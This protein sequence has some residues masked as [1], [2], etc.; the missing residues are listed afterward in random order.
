MAGPAAPSSRPM[1]SS[2]E[3]LQNI[4]KR[5]EI[6]QASLG[7]WR[8]LASGLAGRSTE[9]NEA[10]ASE[11]P[12][13]TS[14]M[15]LQQECKDAEADYS[16]RAEKMC[17]GPCG[18]HHASGNTLVDPNWWDTHPVSPVWCAGRKG[19]TV[20]RQREP[21]SDGAVDCRLMSTWPCR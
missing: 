10:K 3:P 14:K 12:W 13:W 8:P 17:M 20:T 18:A 16:S 19:T 5:E 6:P 21:R 1:W 15:K 7:P 9:Q 2:R 11:H 4:W